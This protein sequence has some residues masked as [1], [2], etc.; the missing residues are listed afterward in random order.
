MTHRRR[1]GALLLIG[2]TLASAILTP[3]ATHAAPP[4]GVLP[5]DSAYYVQ[6]YLFPPTRSAPLPSIALPMF[7]SV[8]LGQVPPPWTDAWFRETYLDHP[9]ESIELPLARL[10]P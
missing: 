2:A 7:I 3:P 10:V 8:R 4:G 5:S 6:T 1:L 9:A